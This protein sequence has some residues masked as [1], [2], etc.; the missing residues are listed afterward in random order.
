LPLTE[1]LSRAQDFFHLNYAFGRAK[2][3]TLDTY[4]QFADRAGLR[5]TELIDI[6]NQT[7]PTFAHWS[8]QVEANREQVRS[9]IG[10]EG[11][12]HFRA[13]C[14]ILPKL[15]NERILGYGL[16]VAVKD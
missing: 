5:V 2:M 7:F 12:E 6:S 15:W 11:L 1:V 13:S 16:M 10:E 3:E 8:H 9:L 14:R 4:R